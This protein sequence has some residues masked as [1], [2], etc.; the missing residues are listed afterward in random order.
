MEDY[1]KTH[2]TTKAKAAALKSPEPA[3]YFKKKMA[4]ELRA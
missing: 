3:A 1:T 4:I 2:F